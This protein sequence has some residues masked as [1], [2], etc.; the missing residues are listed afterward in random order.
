ME[1][2]F[3]VPM[4]PSVPRDSRKE[5]ET[6]SILCSACVHRRHLSKADPSRATKL[7]S[8]RE[9]GKMEERNNEKR[10]KEKGG[11]RSKK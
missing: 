8:P 9:E 10:D 4:G 5:K 7:M 2:R 3:G 1:V 6:G 11:K